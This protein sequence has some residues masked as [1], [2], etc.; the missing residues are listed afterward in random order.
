VAFSEGQAGWIP[1]FVEQMDKIWERSAQLGDPRKRLPRPPSEY[2]PGR[3]YASVFDDVHSLVGR[4]SIGMGHLTVEVD[5]PHD[6]S[7]FPHTTSTLEKLVQT[8]G[9]SPL[10]TWQ[11]LRGN[12]IECYG[13][14]RIGLIS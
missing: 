8:A 6:E 2:L 10:E 9:L 5:Y 14:Q 7:T 13:L 1:F 12:A 11:L 4:A 3:V